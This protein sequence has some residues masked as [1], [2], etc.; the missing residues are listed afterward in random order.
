MHQGHNIPWNIISS[1]FH[2]VSNDRRF[3][4]PK[5]SLIVHKP[6]EKS[7][8]HFIRKFGTAIRTFSKTERTKYPE[9][10]EPLLT[11]KV[12]SDELREKYPQY[13]DERNQNIEAWFAA[14]YS[15]SNANLA[16]AVK[17]LLH[18]NEM[19]TLLML[20]QH[21]SIPLAQLNHLSWGH[22]FGFSRVKESALRAYMFFN[23]AEATG[24][25]EN[26]KYTTIQPEYSSLLSEIASS[27]DYP[28]QQV[29]HQ[30]FLREC[31]VLQG[32][33]SWVP[34]ETYV[35]SDYARLQ[36]YLKKLF[37]LMY[38]YDML[39]AECGAEPE[40]DIE[41]AYQFP[42]RGNIK[43]GWDESQQRNVLA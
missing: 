2:F 11:G 26:G 5:T 23:A 25:L 1:N 7:L 37:E 6:D 22:H 24:I 35:H 39:L 18:E 43:V 12:F 15:T 10:F 40:W 31:G 19:S 9:S 32:G 20:A 36:R 8:K 41:L 33:T 30:E 28:A 13:L 34:E 29:T 17:I 4:S 38:R 42:L 16:E 27:M 3:T 14:G 21:P